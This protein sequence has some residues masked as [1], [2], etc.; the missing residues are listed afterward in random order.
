MLLIYKFKKCNKKDIPSDD[1][2]IPQNQGDS[3][4]DKF[5]LNLNIQ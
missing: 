3:K 5:T 2:Y 4:R 1:I